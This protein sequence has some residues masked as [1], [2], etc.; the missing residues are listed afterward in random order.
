MP[1]K[2]NKALDQRFVR[3]IQAVNVQLAQKYKVFAVMPETRAD[4]PNCIYDRIHKA[5]SGKYNGTGPT[6][7]TGNV[8]P[9]CSGVGYVTTKRTARLIANV[10]TSNDAEAHRETAHGQLARD[11]A[12]LKV[13]PRQAKIITSADHFLVDGIRF[14]LIGTPKGRGLLSRAMVWA[15]VKE[16]R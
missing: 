12:I 11:E 15:H 16:D 7:F 9:V 1:I 13:L 2:L 3:E 5:S 10:I 8:C 14:K 6:P 4:C